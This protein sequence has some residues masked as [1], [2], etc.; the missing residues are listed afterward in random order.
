MNKN[1]LDILSNSNKEI[2]NQRIMDY[3][4]GRLPEAQRNEVERW[5]AEEAAMGEDALEGIASLSG[6]QSVRKNVDALNKELRDIL[7]NKR[8]RKRKDRLKDK[9]WSYIAVILLLLLAVAAY[10]VIRNL[11]LA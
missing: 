9:P 6:E 4:S 1:L 11:L 8:Q 2:D 10:W 5:L 3:L 7:R